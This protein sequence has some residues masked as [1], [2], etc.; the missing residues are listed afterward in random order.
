MRP[1]ALR[2]YSGS[3]GSGL[4]DGITLSLSSVIGSLAGLLSWVIATRLVD[5]AQVG[6]A[7]QVVS[8]FILVAGAAQLNLGVGILRWLPQAGHRTTTLVWGSLFL[9]MPLSALVGLVYVLILPDLARTSAGTGPFALGVLFFVLATAGWGVFVVHDFILVA[10][11]KPWW[12]VWRNGLFAIVR[13]GLLIALGIAGFG[14]QGIVLSW[15]GPIVVWILGGSLVIAVLVRRASRSATG[16]VL[17]GRAEAV[18][19]LGPT[20]VA[21]LGAAL[22]YNQVTVLATERFGDVTGAKFFIAWQ[23]V[24]VID[25][26]AVFFMNSVVVGVAREP[27]RAA[28]LAEVARKRLMMFFLPVLAVG[29]LVAEPALAIVFGPAYAEATDV[30]RLLMLGLAFRLV[31]VHELGI[32]QA[33]GRAL[34]FARLQLTSTLLV[35]VV[36]IVVPVGTGTVD[37]LIPVAIGYVLVQVICAAFVL[38]PRARRRADVEVPSP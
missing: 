2:Q 24:T 14:A 27:H 38:F 36:V 37:S 26:T 13:I 17:P 33:A 21:Q 20:A 1:R 8:A 30:L 10:I 25:I 18:R 22:L 4:N 15:V 5:P 35:L 29:A 6:Q 31:V 19:F 34:A 3:G 28:E 12:A 7:S 9:I 23:A 11:G 32:R 16:G